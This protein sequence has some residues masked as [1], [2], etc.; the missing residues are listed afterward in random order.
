MN[1]EII[2]VVIFGYIGIPLVISI[3]VFSLYQDNKLRKSIQNAKNRHNEYYINEKI[4]KRLNI[5]LSD[6]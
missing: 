5:D 2:F 4:K 1:H 6:Y 3:I